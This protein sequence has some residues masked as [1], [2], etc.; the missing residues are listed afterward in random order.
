MASLLL[1]RAGAAL[2]GAVLG[3]AGTVLGKLAG[4]FAGNAIDS[5]LFGVPTTTK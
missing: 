4:T 1:A 3:P 2:G 5:A